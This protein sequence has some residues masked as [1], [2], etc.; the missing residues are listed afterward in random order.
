MTNSSEVGHIFC[1][2]VSGIGT[3][4]LLD[5]DTAGSEPEIHVSVVNASSV[6]GIVAGT[7]PATVVVMV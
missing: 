2:A 5:V 1:S 4:L 3:E 6:V 7:E